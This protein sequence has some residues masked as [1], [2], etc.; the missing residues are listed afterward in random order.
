M[1][2]S[3]RISTKIDNKEA[4]ADLHDLERMVEKTGDNIKATGQAASSFGDSLSKATGKAGKSISKLQDELAAVEAEIKR[5]QDD[6]DADLASAIT[7][8]QTINLLKIEEIALEKLIKKR[9]E[10][11]AKL[12]EYAA[13]QNKA[14]QKQA[15]RDAGQAIKGASKEVSAGVADQAFISQISSV[16][17]YKAILRDLQAEMQKYEAEAARVAQAKGLNPNDILAANQQ[18]QD[19]SRR[20]N[21]LAK[22]MSTFKKS[23]SSA[24]SRGRKEVNNFGTAM[25]KATKKVSRLALA[26]F[27]MRSIYSAISRVTQTYLSNNE[28]AAQSV[29]TLGNTIAEMFGPAI[30][31][32]IN[33][34]MTGLA[35]LNAFVKGLTG[36]DFAAR[37]NAKALAKQAD[38]T[39]K[40]AKA[41]QERQSAGFDE[42]TKLTDTSSSA[43]A[44]AGGGAG[45]GMADLPDI[46]AWGDKMVKA[47]QWVKE[48]L[49]EILVLVGS[50]AGGLLAW[51]IA[52]AFGA[53]IKQCSGWFLIIS[54]AITMVYG[55]C[56]AW[57]NGLDW[58]NFFM[59]VGGGA[60]VVGGLGLVFGSTGAAIGAVVV[61]VT[62]LITG[63]V[64]L[65]NNGP[66]LENIILI[67]VGAIAAF[68]AGV[69]LLNGSLQACPIVWIIDI[70][71]ALIAVI[72][73]C[74]VYWDEIREAIIKCWEAIAEFFGDIANWFKERWEDAVKWTKNAW[75]DI[76][77]FFAGIWK[78]IKDVFI[79][80][81]KWFGDVFT[82]A[83]NGIKKA[84]S[85]VG[86]FFTGV[87]NTITSIF[88]KVGTAIGN[89]VSG[90]FKSAIN[91]VLEKAIGL[92]NGFIK[93]ING[94]IG[95]INK[96][97]GV[98]IKKIG[99]IDV[100]KLAKGGIVNNP[101]RGVLATI[102][103]AGA[104]AVLPLEKNTGWMD[105]LAEK[106]NGGDKNIVVQVV[107]S[108][109]KI[110]E[111][112]INLNKK[113]EFATN[114][115]R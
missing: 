71:I 80:V 78:G 70:I 27:S 8:E 56:D 48:H 86:S 32:I 95:I 84:F 1:D 30:E 58:E 104:E 82:A 109:K 14:D 37:A 64:D 99:L 49:E 110:H 26:L 89:A 79:G 100:P 77:A 65:I 11:I 72:A 73:L 108:G 28:A 33:L 94:A 91:W 87:W 22:G 102:G 62:A 15:D 41:E 47:G 23:A 50:I 40:L 67:A 115:A 105:I 81:G 19:L 20:V 59:I 97:P 61:G 2:G 12:N 90:A 66:T 16:R 55:V 45:V 75:K 21:N 54:G 60:A 34:L 6:T 35:Y 43:G 39:T 68:T 31:Y 92:I 83:W 4:K 107:L 52:D 112:I 98:S 63:I 88:S 29:A 113:R 7:D 69:W 85:A 10:L 36:V 24:F 9:D 101:G 25:Q 44:G 111:E 76:V 46:G 5:I 17:E 93:T 38:S 3:I 96:I 51:K 57:I 103:E 13:A 53:S 18:Y 42:Q 114:G 74:I 106:I